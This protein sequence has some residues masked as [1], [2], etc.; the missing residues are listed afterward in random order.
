MIYIYFIFLG[1]SKKKAKHNAA[2]LMIKKLFKSDAPGK[3][4]ILII[5]IILFHLFITIEK[6]Y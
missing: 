6:L 4:I 2:L 3:Y 5:Y 1:M